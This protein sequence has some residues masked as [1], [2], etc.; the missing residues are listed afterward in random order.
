MKAHKFFQNLY[1]N[2]WGYGDAYENNEAVKSLNKLITDNHAL[3]INLCGYKR[4]LK[5]EYD[6]SSIQLLTSKYEGFAMTLLEGQMQGIP[7]ISYN[8][9]YGPSEIVEDKSTGYLIPPD[10][11]NTLT[12][13]LIYLLKHKNVASEFSKN[14]YKSAQRFSYKEIKQKWL[15]LINTYMN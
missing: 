4:D 6:T 2:I 13:K 3:Y 12:D 10:D 7:A 9:D 8:V 1:L 15:N 11:I 5:T 14:A